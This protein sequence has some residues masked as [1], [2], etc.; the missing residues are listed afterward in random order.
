MDR[1]HVHIPSSPH[2]QERDA[3]APKPG[4]HIETHQFAHS[5]K[6]LYDINVVMTQLSSLPST[7]VLHDTGCKEATT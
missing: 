6:R 3:L 7:K 2:V 4:R 1:L 5:Y